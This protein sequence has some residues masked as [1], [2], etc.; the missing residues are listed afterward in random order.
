MSE[1]LRNIPGNPIPDGATAGMMTA[2]DGLQIRYALFPSSGENGT[3]VL[4]PGRNECI[5]KYFETVQ[6]L[7]ARGFSAAMLDWRGQ[8]GSERLLPDPL[9]GHVN[10]FGQYLADL[11]QLFLEIVLPDCRPPYAVLAHSMGALIALLAVPQLTNR[12]RRVVLCAPLLELPAPVPQRPVRMLA[13]VMWGSGLGSRYILGAS[14]R[15][16]PVPLQTNKLTSDAERYARNQELLHAFP[17]LF[18]GG[19][20][21]AWTRAALKA[22]DRVHAAEFRHSV[23]LPI[24]FLA[25][26]ADRVV[27]TPAIERYV[28]GLRSA[29][30]LT[31]D[32][33]RHELFQ[34][35]DFYREQALAAFEAFAKPHP[36]E[37]EET[38]PEEARLG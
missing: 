12:V 33:A 16:K 35:A 5:E 29:H 24:L 31:V 3:V 27:S 6:D 15:G 9:R 4:L 28:L 19:P 36:D 2:A 7:A 18:I 37:H 10:S 25:S 26:G 32:G 30:V 13:S 23:R 38:E 34:E 8:G 14:R 20:T 21:A 22:M 17:E 1:L 11:D